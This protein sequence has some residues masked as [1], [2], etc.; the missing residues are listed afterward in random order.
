MS[1]SVHRAFARH[2]PFCLGEIKAHKLLLSTVSEVFKQQFF[3]PFPDVVKE[4]QAFYSLALFQV[5]LGCGSA[6]I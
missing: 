6:L 3:G 4:G 1:D 2:C 5:D